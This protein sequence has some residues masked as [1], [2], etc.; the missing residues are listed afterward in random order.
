MKTAIACL[1][2]AFA[3]APALA[4]KSITDNNKTVTIDCAKDP[5]ASIEG[6]D[7]TVALTGACTKVTVAGNRN[8]VAVASSADVDVTGN[9][10]NVALVAVDELDVPGNKNVVSY[11]SAVK[12]GGKVKVSNPGTDNKVTASK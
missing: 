5:V 8:K 4:D 1:L 11:K 6:N 9:E 10:N 12:K 3:A 2:L 7:N